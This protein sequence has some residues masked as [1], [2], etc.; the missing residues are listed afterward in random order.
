[1]HRARLP[2]GTTVVLVVVVRPSGL[3]VAGPGLEEDLKEAPP[4]EP[5]SVPSDH[6]RAV[7][8]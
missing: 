8:A 4:E 2:N 5:V 3:T 1:V 7:V 6:F